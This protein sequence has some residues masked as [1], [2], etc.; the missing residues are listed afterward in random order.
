[1]AKGMTKFLKKEYINLYNKMLDNKKAQRPKNDDFYCYTT[2]VINEY[3][4]VRAVCED[5]QA[6]ALS[7]EEVMGLIQYLDSFEDR[8]EMKSKLLFY[9]GAKYFYLLMKNMDLLKE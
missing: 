9:T 6:I 8:E 1:M 4:N 2:K 5:K 7:V 3:P